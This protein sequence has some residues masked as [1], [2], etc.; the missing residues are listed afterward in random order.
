M[1]NQILTIDHLTISYLNEGNLSP[2]LR[3]VSFQMNSGEVVGIVGESGCGKSTL[4]YAIMNYLPENGEV[5]KGEINFLGRDLLK[6]SNK[7]M[8]TIRGVKISIVPQDPLTSLNPSY[9][10]RD[11]ISEL[12]QTHLK[13]SKI[14]AYKKVIELLESV[15]V[16]IPHMTA[17]K[18][19][20]EISGGQ[21]QRVLIAMAFCLK[22]VLIILDEP[23]TGLDVTTESI[24]LELIKNLKNQFNCSILYIT[25]NLGVVKNICDRILT[26]Y[27]G[28]I[29]EVGDVNSVFNE[30]RHPYTYGLLR[31][32]PQLEEKAIHH[33]LE[34]IEG[35]LPI[36]DEVI[37]SCIFAPRCKL[38]KKRCFSEIPALFII[39]PNRSSRCF[40]HDEIAKYYETGN[41]HTM[42][43]EKTNKSEKYSSILIIKNLSINY[44]MK[45]GYLHAIDG[46]N[47]E[48]GREQIWGVVGESGCGKT[49]LARSIAGLLEIN[50][51]KIIFQNQDISFDY[52]KR[53]KDLFKKIQMVFQNPDATLNP[54][55]TIEQIISRPIILHRKIEKSQIRRTVIEL[56][57][58][59]RLGERYL[60]KYPHE[61]SGGEKQRVGIARA[62]APQPDLIICDEPVSNLDV[63][64]QAGILNLL[65]D[66]EQKLKITYLFISHDLN[67]IRYVSDKVVVF[68]MGKVCEQGPADDLFHPPYHPYTESLLA[69]IPLIQS[70]I[71]QRKMHLVGSPPSSLQKIAGCV[72]NS[73][74]PRKLG[75]ICE[76]TPPP[77]V[78]VDEDHFLFCHISLEDL[79][80]EKPVL[81]FV[82]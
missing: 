49:T 33:K 63:S 79:T 20:H 56:L 51:G 7:E 66:L 38:A 75:L 69:S 26:F 2:A 37:Q 31:S 76:S 16:P 43:F 14:E 78:N 28:E 34:V 3:D 80:R 8:L 65:V 68:Y 10:I 59:V 17:E 57:D 1:S 73:R 82:N 71:L 29:V 72:F 77:L 74:C 50:D 4:A 27:A 41:K 58:M 12:L 22:P 32:I 55:K 45:S 35:N 47:L 52:T 67:V 60:D 62:L 25:H 46:I 15:N 44:K 64:I 24:I 11:Q 70:N 53:G 36:L 54:Q 21:Q 42:E 61:L 81:E 18:Y 23:T 9:R 13:I 48:C 30:P 6:L 40:Y 39:D 5:I 19:P